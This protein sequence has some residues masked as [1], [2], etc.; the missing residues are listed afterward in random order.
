[1]KQYNYAGNGRGGE[2][3]NNK[4]KTYINYN[5]KPVITPEITQRL[6][7]FNKWFEDNYDDIKTILISKNK[8]N[9]E[10]ISDTYYK[11]YRYIEYGGVITSNLRYYW[12]TSYF[13]NLFNYTITQTKNEAKF[14]TTSTIDVIDDSEEDEITYQNNI[15]LINDIQ[16][17]LE[18][19]IED[20]IDR[21]L[22][23]IYMNLKKHPN[24]KMTYKKLSEI[25]N[26]PQSR[27][28]ETIKKIKE[29]INKE[30]KHKR[31]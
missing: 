19:N 16:V 20:D 6:K 28:A 26:I 27:I 3:G 18:E 31:L 8:F 13:T 9:D 21:E 22:F 11:V 25:T 15:Q 23:I 24:Y 2:Y 1:M 5:I 7:E 30:F 12:N 17:W 10:V 4:G 29:Q 14:T